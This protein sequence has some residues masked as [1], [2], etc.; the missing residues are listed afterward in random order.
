MRLLFLIEI[1]KTFY[2]QFL[3]HR[4]CPLAILGLDIRCQCPMFP[5]KIP[6][7]YII[8]TNSIVSNSPPYQ[9]EQHRLTSVLDVFSVESR[10]EFHG[11][12]FLCHF[13]ETQN[14]I[15]NFFGS[16]LE[17]IHQIILTFVVVTTIWCHF[18]AR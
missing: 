7:K 1:K 16:F 14:L 6:I 12:H 11:Y 17:L 4:H 8:I 3:Y 2:L 9:H 18:S 15:L 10:I 13:L 5:K